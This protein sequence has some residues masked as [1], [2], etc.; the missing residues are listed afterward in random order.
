MAG[1]RSK[2]PTIHD[3][4][5]RAGVSKSLVSLVMRDSPHVSDEKRA[6]V[7]EAADA[8]GYRPNAVAR[9]LVRQRSWVLGVVLSDLHNPFFADVADG[10]EE[11]ATAAGY[12][13][14][15][16]SGFLDAERERQSVDSLLQ[17]RADGLILLGGVGGPAS[18]SA[19]AAAVP[20][21]MVSG[22]T[23]AKTMDSVVND[24]R[25]GTG[26]L[27]DHLVELGH[28]RIAH[29]SPRSGPAGP[30]RRRGYENRMRHHGLDTEVRV[31]EG[32]FTL[33]GGAAAMRTLL[34]SSDP[35]TAV[36]APNDFAALGALE[37]ADSAGVAVPDAVSV[38]G[39]DHIAL[40]QIARIGLTTIAQPA[41]ELGRVAV[42]LIRERVEGD[43]TEARH[44][45]LPP[46]LVVGTTTAPPPRR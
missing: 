5:D 20:T 40:A 33:E 26:L 9:S 15:L 32:A 42:S 17:L 14:L 39:Y 7:M 27:V 4:A 6:A 12:R 43:R 38:T 10:I 3:V 25:L 37:A 24:D 2:H 46:S 13:A 45:V 23:D 28:R 8:L 31:V 21:V 1:K 35:P 41:A 11:G 29:I 44:I 19:A 16:A 34:A 22:A 36:V 30:E 18:Y